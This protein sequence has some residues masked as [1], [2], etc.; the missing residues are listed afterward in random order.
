MSYKPLNYKE[1]N[2]IAGHYTPSM[3]KAYNNASF[4]FWERSLFQRAQSV[5]QVD[6][7]PEEWTGSVRDFFF[8]CLLNFGFVCVFDDPRYGLSFQPCTL[9][10]MD[11]YYQPSGVIVSNR[12]LEKEFTIGED[13]ELIKLTPD[14]EG[15][16]D[17]VI[18]YAEKLAVLDNAINISLINNKFAY[19]LGARNKGMAAALKKMLDKI[20][21]GE[22]AVIYDQRILNDTKDRDVPYQFF[23]RDNLK[24]SYI[25]TEQL[26]DFQTI[27]NSFDAE[28]G[29]P[30]VPYQKK[31]RMVTDEANSKVFDAISRATIWIE[32]LNN[33]VSRVNNM[34][35]TDIKFSLRYEDELNGISNN[36]PDRALQL[37]QQTIRQNDNA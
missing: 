18:F 27:I 2:L 29:I 6:G 9:K 5:I 17:I 35:G 3:I 19:F 37:Q 23:Q 13:T 32:T 30:T 11:F 7:I 14:F 8:Y 36:E 31:E 34:F 24:N 10:G 16:A 25:T 22:P 26:Q 28:I 21:K 20:N 15:I 1:I 4:K 12:Y 33:S